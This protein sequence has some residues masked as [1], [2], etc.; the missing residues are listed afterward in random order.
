M[1]NF[2]LSFIVTISLSL[3]AFKVVK[4]Y[5][6]EEKL[7][8]KSFGINDLSEIDIDIPE[9]YLNYKSHDMFLD[10]IAFYESSNDYSKVNRLGYLG[11][12]QFHKKTLKLIGIEVSKKDFLNSPELQEYAMEVLLRENKNTLD[13]FISKY[14]E[15]YV[16]GVLV[17]E[18]GILAAAHLGGA[19]NVIEWFRSGKDFKDAN[20]TSIKKYMER[21]SGYNL[22]LE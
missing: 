22:N 13:Y 17:T 6:I 14:S 10:K 21:F 3:M 2:F 1:K 7:K 19:G 4:V 5:S 16:H 15:R 18:S 11:K 9:L 8:T 20:G 12:Y